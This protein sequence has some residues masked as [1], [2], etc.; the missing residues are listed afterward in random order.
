M[1][2]EAA[3]N[4]SARCRFALLKIFSWMGFRIPANKLRWLFSIPRLFPSLRWSTRWWNWVL[5]DSM[6]VRTCAG[7]TIKWT[8]CFPWDQHWGHSRDN[9]LIGSDTDS[10]RIWDR[11]FISKYF[12]YL[13]ISKQY[14]SLGTLCSIIQ[15]YVKS[16]VPI[17]IHFYLCKTVFFKHVL[18]SMGFK[19]LNTMT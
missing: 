13:S 15:I 8:E 14:S 19:T 3:L 16:G 5:F 9:L 11:G 18:E 12:W 2:F 6:S 10:T 4:F 1:T 7:K 17:P